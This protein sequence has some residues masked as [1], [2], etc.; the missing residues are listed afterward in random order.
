VPGPPTSLPHEPPEREPGSGSIDT[1][2]PLGFLA[3]WR[4]VATAARD[5]PPSTRAFVGLTGLALL[6]ALMLIL[7]PSGPAP[8]PAAPVLLDAEPQIRVRILRR[9]TEASLASD[10]SLVLVD[11][12]GETHTVASPVTLTIE[13]GEF[14]LTSPDA[15][16]RFPIAEPLEFE[17]AR[18]ALNPGAPGSITLHAPLRV[19]PA[20]NAPDRF[21]VVARLPIESYL[22]GVLA[23][24]LY[25]HWPL[26][27]FKAQAVAARSYA[28]HDRELAQRS[29]RNWDVQRGTRSQ[30]F[31]GETSLQ[32]AVDAVER[33]RGQVLT[34]EGEILRAYYSSSIGGR[35]ASAADVFRSDEGYEFH[36]ADPIQA[37][38]REY[39][40]QSSPTHRWQRERNVIDLSNRIRAWGR[41]R[42]HPAKDLVR[43]LHLSESAHNAVGR[44]TVYTL[45]DSR[46]NT[47]TI[48]AE[49][50]R[51]A[52]NYTGDEFAELAFA[53][54]VLSSDI[55]FT[56]LGDTVRILG[57]G[58][59][60]GVG[61]CQHSAAELARRGEPY[62]AILHRYYPGAQIVRWYE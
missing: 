60:H 15:I 41:G 7:P 49:Q 48:T 4:A 36:H 37:T 25:S 12:H 53:D 34:F 30:S 9:V 20:I 39:F 19:Y 23:G 5:W 56:I 13:G 42:D 2:S 6:L 26:G 14:T 22:P 27:A 59:G 18:F 46:R 55:G 51:V 62:T 24:E 47:A 45:E 29:G 17:A 11:R 50:L 32:V 54:R 10:Q 28:L 21:D 16:L 33:T 57:R 44:P 40:D 8:I 43:L 52:C 1:T 35:A 3:R 38:E 58:Y 61:M 31:V